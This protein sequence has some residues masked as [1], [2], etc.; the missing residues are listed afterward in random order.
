MDIEILTSQGDAF[1]II[2]GV[3]D[4]IAEFNHAASMYGPENSASWR[5]LQPPPPDPSAAIKA[6][7][8]ALEAQ[9]TP[10]MYRES[11]AG[12]LATNENW[13]NADGSYRTSAQQLA[14][15]D[16]QIVALRAQLQDSEEG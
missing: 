3:I 1:T 5:E 6:Q 14:W 8:A 15:L 2:R 10:R 9:Q 16:S 7:I 11:M 4:P 13:K 12:N